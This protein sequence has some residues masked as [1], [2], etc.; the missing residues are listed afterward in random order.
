M[1]AWH[2]GGAAAAGAGHAAQLSKA[3][4]SR[5]VIALDPPQPP[6][7]SVLHRSGSRG[8][9]D[10]HAHALQLL[11]THAAC[12]TPRSRSLQ[13]CGVTSSADCE[14]ALSQHA[15]LIG[16]IM[17]PKAKRSVSDETAAAI[18]AVAAQAGATAVGVFVDEDAATITKRA[19]KAG[20]RY[21]Q[22]HGDG[23]RAALHELPARFGIVYV[24]QA[25]PEGVVQTPLPSA[26][27]RR[28]GCAARKVRHV[29]A[30]PLRPVCYS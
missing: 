26:I 12:F 20:L 13:I 23:A 28:D 22:L 4:R 15:D 6:P 7:V 3:S 2:R 1:P 24:L 11:A 9:E 8:M 25:S 19:D 21:V 10:D 16:M 17:W 29:I 14:L 5:Y 27:P 18:S 30:M